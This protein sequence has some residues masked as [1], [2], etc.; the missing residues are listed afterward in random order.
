MGKIA[1]LM[2]GQ[3][4]QYPGM[5]REFFENIKEVHDFFGVAE[6]I[7]PGTLAQIISG[8]EEELKQT[9]NTQPCVFLA[10]MASAMALK[11]EGINPD[12]AAGFS[13]GE[14]AGLAITGAM[15][16][17][18]AFKLVCTRGKAMNKAATEH[19]GVMIAVLRMDKEELEKVCEETGVY[20]VNY[21]CP[22]QI[23]VSGKKNEMKHLMEILSE[24]KVRYVELATSGPF[25]TPYMG[26]ASEEVRSVL[27]EKKLYNINSTE[28]P[29]YANMTGTPYP[30]E[31]E[32]IA[33]TLAL[34]A[35]NS[36]RWEETIRNMV[37]DGIDTFIECGPGKTLS[38]FV[39]R[40]APEAKIYNVSDMESLMKVKEALAGA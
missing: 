11:N 15:S 10:D 20:P 28:I 37:K 23:V 16:K 5:A 9:E 18:D 36:V 19:E 40:I 2:A 4:S 12:A 13:L 6:A 34:Q 25:H 32:E 38:G 8:T 7:R 26:G 17:E 35:S 31:E 21:N 30:S 14:V 3:G 39:K 29:L 33:E 27:K 1:F 24:K 22:G